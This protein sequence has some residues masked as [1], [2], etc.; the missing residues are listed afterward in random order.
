MMYRMTRQETP[1]PVRAPDSRSPVVRLRELLGDMPP[2]KPGI[3]MAV[4]EPQHP[5]PPFVG[6]II[7]AHVDE[8]GRYPMNKGLDE[9][10]VAVAGWLGRR[11]ALPRPVDPANEVLVLNGTREGLFLAALAA[12]NWVTP[13]GGKPAV[14]IPN[15]FYAAYAAGAIGADCEPIYLPT[16]RETGFLPDLDALDDELLAR[17]VA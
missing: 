8:F 14:L 16:T 11:Y 10:G 1:L 17:T 2:G 5:I 4:G 12:K 9:F 7:A 6:P 3:S 15:P 13:R